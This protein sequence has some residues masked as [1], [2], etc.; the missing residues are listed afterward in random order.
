MR[1]NTFKLLCWSS[2]NPQHSTLCSQ[3]KWLTDERRV[4]RKLL[5]GLYDGL[6]LRPEDLNAVCGTL[7]EPP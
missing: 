2:E 1:Q 3:M 5:H 6:E 4:V 7:S